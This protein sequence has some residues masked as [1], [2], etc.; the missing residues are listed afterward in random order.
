MASIKPF[1]AIRPNPVYA[2]QLVFTTPQVESVALHDS[3]KTAAVPLKHVLETVA[4]QHPETREGQMNAYRDI[5][6]ALHNLLTTGRLNK[7]T[8]PGIYVYETHQYGCTQ[9]GIWALTSLDEVA[10]VKVHELTFADSLRRLKSYREH[11]L[12]EGSPVLLTY[13]ANE[14]INQIIAYTKFT[15]SPFFLG[16]AEGEHRLWRIDDPETL[17]KIILAFAAIDKVYLAD[18][19]HRLSSAK[20]LAIEQRES[21]RAVINELSALYMSFDQLQIREYHRVV[22]PAEPISK[23]VFFSALSKNF[24]V[25]EAFS[26]RPVQPQ[27]NHQLGMRL[28]GEWFRLTAKPSAYGGRSVSERLDA[29]LLQ[30]LVLAPLF[31]IIDPGTEVRL[32]C[33]GGPKA[34]EQI[35]LLCSEH[36]E[37]V[38]FTLS[39]L[40][41]EQLTEVADAGETL[42]PKS[43]WIN[44]KIPYGL[45]LYQQTLTQP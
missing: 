5:R 14:V 22:L 43:T 6:L 19:H 23:P 26:N 32:K 7:D 44:P 12:L 10:E 15:Q 21:G 24:Y 39:A 3:G 2:D 42:P 11:T 1:R 40:T 31:G 35:D 8:S 4:R 30:E 16:N 36:P 13:E 17:E 25:Q 38:V 20:A 9:T 37:A 28:D 45:L 34:F 41:I 27:K 33:A 18:G 29:A